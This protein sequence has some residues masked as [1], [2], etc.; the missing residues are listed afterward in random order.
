MIGYLNIYFCKLNGYKNKFHI[1]Y[2]C[3]KN[4]LYFCKSFQNNVINVN[5]WLTG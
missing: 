3:F 1:N 5:L 2:K 4:K